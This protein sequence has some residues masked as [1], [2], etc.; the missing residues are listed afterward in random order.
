MP[1]TPAAGQVK[2]QNHTCTPGTWRLSH[3]H[4]RP[5]PSADSCEQAELGQRCPTGCPARWGECGVPAAGSFVLSIPPCSPGHGF[6]TGGMETR[7]QAGGHKG[8][9]VCTPVRMG[10]LTSVPH[11]PGVGRRTLSRSHSA[12]PQL[13]P[14]ERQSLP[15]GHGMHSSPPTLLSDLVTSGHSQLLHPTMKLE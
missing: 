8:G 6:Q 15:G 10:V 12:Q 5:L 9:T 4:A 3:P 14:E 7:A 2:P 11:R 1:G 13:P